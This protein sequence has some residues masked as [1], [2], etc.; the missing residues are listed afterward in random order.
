MANKEFY[1]QRGILIQE[2]N[3]PHEALEL[4]EKAL[5]YFPDHPEA[6][7]RVSDLL[8]D[9]Y[10]QKMSLEKGMDDSYK[11][12]PPAS[13]Q[14]DDVV[15][16]NGTTN[17]VNTTTTTNSTNGTT[18]NAT[19]TTNTITTSPKLNTRPRGL[20]KSKSSPPTTTLSNPSTTAP[21]TTLP[22]STTNI[23]EKNNISNSNNPEHRSR[24][25]ARDRA[26]GLL[27]CLTKL[28]TGWDQPEAWLALARV[29]EESGQVERAREALWWCVDLEDT[30]PVRGWECVGPGGF[31]L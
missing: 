4:F 13:K 17:H 5:S 26:Y 19:N 10:T 31:V 8:M 30:R 22:D 24:L 1:L 12:A 14:A 3:E 29:H 23:D 27:S 2:E 25:A 6:T 20:S 21:T 7:I 18:A 9:M 15:G 28:G 16:V 11:S